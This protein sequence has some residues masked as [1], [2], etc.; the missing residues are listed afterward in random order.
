MPKLSQIG[1]LD[2]PM[3]TRCWS[4]V[5]CS[6]WFLY[7]FLILEWLIL[8][9]LVNLCCRVSW[10][11]WTGISM[12]ILDWC[13]NLRNCKFSICL[14]VVAFQ[15]YSLCIFIMFI[16][17]CSADLK[18]ASCLSSIWLCFFLHILQDID[19]VLHI[20]LLLWSFIEHQ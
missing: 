3:N 11:L 1:L 13:L 16:Y 9:Y 10:V 5:T 19:E 6:S 12:K 17:N 14:W 4:L 20:A 18:M 8:Y 2:I 7:H 15:L